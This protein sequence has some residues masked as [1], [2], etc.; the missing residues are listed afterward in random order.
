MT[1]V[2]GGNLNIV[3]SPGAPVSHFGVGDVLYWG[4]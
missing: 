4:T 2:A 3:V 1:P